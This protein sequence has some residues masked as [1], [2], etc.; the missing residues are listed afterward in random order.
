M[1]SVSDYV[2][3]PTDVPAVLD[4]FQEMIQKYQF[5]QS[6][7][8]ARIKGLQEKIPEMRSALETVRFLVRKH[9]LALETQKGGRRPKTGGDGDTVDDDEEEE[10]LD[11]DADDLADEKDDDGAK[12]IQTSLST[13]FQLNPTLYA[14]A[15]IPLLPTPPPPSSASTPAEPNSPFQIY[16]W[17][18]ANT[19]VS[20][21]LPEAQE[22]LSSKLATAQSTLQTSEEDVEFLREQITSLEVAVAR[23][24]NWDVGEKRKRKGAG[25]GK[26]KAGKIKG[27]D[28]ADDDD[29]GEAEGGQGS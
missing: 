14:H 9:R 21:P 10:E 2:K 15:S 26:G 27:K 4:R 23:V 20:Y 16:I 3:T 8:E 19:L 28:D 5:M 11:A 29:D 12:E 1:T 7:V 25:E 17:L 6:N 18:G 22:L 24:W 13:T